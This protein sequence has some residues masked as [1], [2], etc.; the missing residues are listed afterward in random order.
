MLLKAEVI[1][2][3]RR[4]HKMGKRKAQE[5]ATLETVGVYNKGR[6]KP[7]GSR[8]QRYYLRTKGTFGKKKKRHTSFD[9]EFTTKLFSGVFN[10]VAEATA[11]K[12]AFVVMLNG[13]RQQPKRTKKASS[14]PRPT[15][16]K[17]QVLD[18]D[19]VLRRKSAAVKSKAAAE[20]REKL[21]QKLRKVT[22]RGDVDTLNRV[23][24]GLSENLKS[25]A[26]MGG[27]SAGG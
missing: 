14:P 8:E 15:P 16:Q 24:D 19:A 13:G 17:K 7:D 20:R 3:C 27:A 4:A 11:H 25:T 1:F 12:P 22:G 23:V 5:P 18:L 9:A 2:V 26:D 6:V 10:T 21:H